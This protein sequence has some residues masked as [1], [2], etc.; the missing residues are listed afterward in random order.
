MSCGVIGHRKMAGGLAAGGRYALLSIIL[1]TWQLDKL[2]IVCAL[3][4]A[5]QSTCV[6]LQYFSSGLEYFIYC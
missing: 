1:N 2:E 4:A 3:E 6:F 5:G